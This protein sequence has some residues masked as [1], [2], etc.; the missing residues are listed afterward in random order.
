[1]KRTTIV[2]AA[3][4]V[5]AWS[6]GAKPSKGQGAAAFRMHGAAE[7]QFKAVEGM[8]GIE[9]ARLWGDMGRNADWGSLFKFKA[10]TDTGWHRHSAHIHLVMVSG[11]L[12]LQPEGGDAAELTAG[13]FADEAAGVAHRTVCKE[14]ADCVFLIHTN[15][16]FDFVKAPEPGAKK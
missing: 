7:V 11:T 3:L 15:K 5:G 9:T 8:Q 4:L 2:A 16:K 12:S 13:A 14:G 1:M 10:G 6:L